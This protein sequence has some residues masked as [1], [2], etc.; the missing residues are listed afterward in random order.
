[1]AL[2]QESKHAVYIKYM[3]DSLSYLKVNKCFC[4][5]KCKIECLVQIKECFIETQS[6]LVFFCVNPCNQLI[7]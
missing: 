2:I 6:F 7:A 5:V 3:I 1:M 4:H